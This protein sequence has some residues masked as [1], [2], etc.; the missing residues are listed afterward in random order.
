MQNESICALHLIDSLALGGAERM[1]VNLCNALAESGCDMHLCVTRKSGPLK[2]FIDP[3]VEIFEL[4]KK[5]TLDIQAI[6][7]LRKYIRQHHIQIVHAHSSSFLM[8]CFMKWLTGVKL[9]WHDH[10]GNRINQAGTSINVLCYLSRWFDQVYA[11][12][13]ALRRWAIDNLSV[14]SDRIEYLANFPNLEEPVSSL[15]D[16]PG[17]KETRIVCTARLNQLKDHPTLVRAMATVHKTIPEAHLLLVGQDLG[18]EYSHKLKELI[19][20]FRLG[21]HVHLLGERTDI[22]AILHGCSVGVLSSMSE[23][24]PVALLEYGLSGLAVV[25]TDVGDCATVLGG[26]EFGKIVPVNNSEGL[27]M[28]I[29]EL[30]QEEAVRSDLAN[31]FRSHVRKCYSGEASA[32]KVLHNYE[33]VCACAPS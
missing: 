15:E 19:Q 25:C 30:L 28:A 8:G 2:Q 17:D 12:N 29:L 4:K 33:K 3:K 31:K 11:V 24:L 10:H 6:F 9:V 7:R 26:G 21:S 13:G 23:G 18:D 1:A 27:A 20:D 32:K 22:A 5:Y 16:L 14:S